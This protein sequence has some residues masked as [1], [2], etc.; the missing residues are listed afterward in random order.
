MLSL[1]P[2]HIINVFVMVDDMLSVVSK[3]SE[4]GRPTLLSDSELV[5]ILLWNVVVVKQKTLKG[6]H[7]W[8]KMYHKQDFPRLPKY[9]A[10]VDHCHRVT[11]LLCW[12]LQQNLKVE[13][14]IVIVDSTM[15]PV[16]KIYRADRHKVAKNIAKFGKNHQ[17]WHYGF[18]LHVSVDPKGRLC[19]LA[20]TGADV[21][22]AQKLPSLVNKNTKVAVGDSGY[23]AS[24]MRK[25]I[26]EKYGTLIVAPPHYK[27]DKKLMT[28]WQDILLKMRPKIESVFGYL[29]EHL[30]LVTSFPRSVKGYLFHYI[31]ILL[32]YQ[33]MVC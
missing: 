16:C 15:L 19:S 10:F 6:I 31:R 20:L 29:K 12:F 11:P 14:P 9:S 2:H 32:G 4:T 24:V 5:T 26:F 3:K 8:I 22:D 23:N 7:E 33:I 25:K 30:N 13:T 27:Q 21:Y 18:K 28:W 1:Q 17:G